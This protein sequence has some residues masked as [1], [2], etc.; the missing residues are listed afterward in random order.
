MR[1]GRMSAGSSFSGWFVVMT[2]S[3]LGE[4]TTPS[5]TLRMPERFSLSFVSQRLEVSPDFSGPAVMAC[6]A[7]TKASES[8]PSAVPDGAAALALPSAAFGAFGASAAGAGASASGGCT[9]VVLVSV[10]C[11]SPSPDLPTS[12]VVVTCLSPLPAGAAELAAPPSRRWTILEIASTSSMTKM[13]SLKPSLIGTSW[14]TMWYRWS[15]IT[16]MSSEFVSRRAR[17]TFT[18]ERCVWCARAL[19][20]E[21]LPVP[22]GPW[23]R[24]PSL[25]G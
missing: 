9:L 1:P 21:V 6:T 23:S 10:A 22:G 7:L 16:S 8:S 15:N 18:I 17:G 25:W 12:R 11:T 20:M 4:S 5:K 2:R 24:S 13:T 14:P 3:L 19:I